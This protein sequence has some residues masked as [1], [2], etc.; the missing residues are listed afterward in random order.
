MNIEDERKVYIY[1]YRSQ[2]KKTRYFSQILD[3]FVFLS[4]SYSG[5]T[6]VFNFLWF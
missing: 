3:I 2:M 6:S 4:F 5:L 1:V